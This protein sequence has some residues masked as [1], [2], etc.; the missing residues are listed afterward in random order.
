MTNTTFFIALSTFE[1]LSMN[2]FFIYCQQNTEKS[3]KQIYQTDLPILIIS[4]AIT[5]K[6]I[7]GMDFKEMLFK[8]IKSPVVISFFLKI[9]LIDS[10]F[11][12]SIFILMKETQFQRKYKFT[13][14]LNQSR[15]QLR[16]TKDQKHILEEKDTLWNRH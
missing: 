5:I 11:Q 15:I 4:G 16:H 1:D 7:K 8:S 13:K 10:S 14:F 2:L 3:H 6:T 12:K 9:R